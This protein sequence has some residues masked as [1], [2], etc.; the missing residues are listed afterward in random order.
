VESLD[1]DLVEEFIQNGKL[2]RGWQVHHILQQD[3]AIADFVKQFKGKDFSIHDSGNLIALPQYA[4]SKVT[5]EQKKWWAERAAEIR[6]D[7]LR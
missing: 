5:T 4:H 3:S 6:E 2:P 7:D 1:D